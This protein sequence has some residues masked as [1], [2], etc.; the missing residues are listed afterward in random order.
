MQQTHTGICH[1]SFLFSFLSFFSQYDMM[2]LACSHRAFFSVLSCQKEVSA[3]LTYTL[4]SAGP[5]PL[6]EQLV[7]C[8]REDILSGRLPPGSHLPSKRSF[9]GNLGVSSI[10]VEAAYGRLM[11]EG[12]VFSEPKRGYFVAQFIHPDSVHTISHTTDIRLP[13]DEKIYPLDLS[14]NRT[15][16]E[17][18]PFSVWTHLLRETVNDKSS[19]LLI[20]SPCGGVPELRSAIAWHLKSFR[21]MNVDPDQIV[22]GA[23]TEYLYGLLIQ[24]LGAERVFCL[25]DPGYRKIAQIYAS[26]RVTCRWAPMDESGITVPGLLNAGADVAHISPTHHFPTGITMPITRRYELLSWADARPGRCIIEDDYDSEFRL[27]GRPIPSLQSI[28]E[29]GRVIYMN[30]FSKSIAS[31]IRISYMVL[32]PALAN[33]YYSRLSFYSCTVSTFEQYTLARFISDGYFEKHLNRMRLFYARLRKQL[34]QQIAASPIADRIDVQERDSGLHFLL[35]LNTR[36]PDAEL[37]ELLSSRGINLLPLS[38]YYR[39]PDNAPE[40]TFVFN[41]S[42][43]DTSMLEQALPVL[44]EFI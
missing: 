5:A 29:H 35:K 7:S 34:L 11:D 18:F 15:P 20:S 4:S 19:E 16:P 13:G 14:G 38:A 39:N 10:T 41:Y 6:Y 24:L 26:H 33:D 43:L 30:T 31:T 27:T 28:D 40:H 37:R 25:E 2:L 36:R 1:D 21:G 44:A 42:S 32:P 23:G 3:L 12:Y 22:V 9:A 17:R 8:L